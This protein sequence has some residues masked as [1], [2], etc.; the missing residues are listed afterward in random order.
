[1]NF[2]MPPKSSLDRRHFLRIS[3]LASLGFAAAAHAQPAPAP[4]PSRGVLRP[5]LNAYSFLEQLNANLAAP[6]KGIDLF[7]VLDF[8][9]QHEIPAADL[10][11]YFFP[12]Y[13]SV[14]KEG[15]VSRIKKYAHER[16]IVISGTG[17]KNDFA[18]AD[19]AVRQ[20]GV[21]LTKTWIEVAASLGAPVIR[22]FAGPHGGKEWQAHAGGARRA[23]VEA[24]MADDLR[25][26]AEHGRRYGV[27][28]AIQ[29]HGD[30]LS[31]AP[32]H[33]SLL[34]R[35]GHEWCGALVDTG[36][37]FTP[38]PYADIAMMVPYAFN[39]QVK[40]TLGSS[41]KSPATDYRRLVRVLL[42]GGYRG[43]LPI[44]TLAMGRKDYD[45]AA[46]VLK[47]L[48]GLRGALAEAR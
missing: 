29:N 48:H 19:R 12:G 24:W 36:K 9:A 27:L 41:L 16:G 5:S 14:P 32:E 11:G 42:D 26:C 1:M 3:A 23:D 38:D 43:F 6:D 21:E 28:V 30:F 46:E 37:Y 40:E 39:W 17:V 33:I 7:G 2:P 18:S 34:R 20:A 22:V 44:E 25:A 10:T 35:V 31:T 4:A 15:Y 8:C 47:V 13:P 45:P